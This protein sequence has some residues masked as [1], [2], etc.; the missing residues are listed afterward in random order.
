MPAGSRGVL[1]GELRPRTEPK[2]SDLLKPKAPQCILKVLG[3]EVSTPDE[4]THFRP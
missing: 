1:Q 3:S 2:V 4:T